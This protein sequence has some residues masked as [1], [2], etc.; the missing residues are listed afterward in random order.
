MKPLP[1]TVQLLLK[2]L[3]E[4]YPEKSP[5]P[6]EDDRKIWMQAGQR[7]LVRI[8]LLRKKRAED[9]ELTLP[10]VLEQN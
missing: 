1:S 10:T 8:L 4:Q 6:N 3:D 5:D 2:E 7:E 9:Q